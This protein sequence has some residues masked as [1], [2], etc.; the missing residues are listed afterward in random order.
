MARKQW[1][2]SSGQVD[3]ATG[4][5]ETTP[6]LGAPF[7]KPG[8]QVQGIYVRSFE[9]AVGHC[10]EF[11]AATPVKVLLD[12][13]GKVSATGHEKT[14]TRFA[15]GALTGFEMALQ[16]MDGFPGFNYGDQVVIVCTGFQKSENAMRSDMPTFDVEISRP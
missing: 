4:R 3:E 10:H 6:I 2:A 9:T 1:K 14:I 16:R 7:W 12:A 15:M 5:F 11:M 8:I 13:E